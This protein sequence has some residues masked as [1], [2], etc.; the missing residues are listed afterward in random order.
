MGKHQKPI[1]GRM[2]GQID[3]DVDAVGLDQIRRCVIVQRTNVAPMV[4]AFLQPRGNTICSTPLL[5]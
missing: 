5:E 3:Q 1:A 4:E 2:A